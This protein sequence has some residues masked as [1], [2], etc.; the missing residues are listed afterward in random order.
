MLRVTSQCCFSEVI[1]DE[2]RKNFSSFPIFIINGY[3]SLI[4]KIKI[5]VI[6]KNERVRINIYDKGTKYAPNKRNVTDN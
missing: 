3:I 2:V 1:E 5:R 4:D 6:S